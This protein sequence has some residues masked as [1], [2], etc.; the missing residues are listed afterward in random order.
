[1]DGMYN[2][3]K[4]ML[5]IKRIQGDVTLF[6]AAVRNFCV[7]HGKIETVISPY[8]LSELNN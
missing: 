8:D 5:T 6:T 1:M 4:K 2:P 7:E 3:D